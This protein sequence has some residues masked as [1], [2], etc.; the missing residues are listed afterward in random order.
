MLANQHN[1]VPARAYHRV[2]QTSQVGDGPVWRYYHA[3]AARIFNAQNDRLLRTYSTPFCERIVTEPS[4]AVQRVHSRARAAK[5]KVLRGHA[6]SVELLASTVQH[7]ASQFEGPR[8]TA[9]NLVVAAR[10][11]RTYLL[12]QKSS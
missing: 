7:A 3:G 1:F 4:F 5:E 10:E 9:R 12:K 8:H 11:R 2:Q 6:R